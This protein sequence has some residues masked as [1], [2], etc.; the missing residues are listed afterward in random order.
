MGN[1]TLIMLTSFIICV[2]VIVIVLNLIQ[3]GRKN[4][5]RKALE[6]LEIEKNKIASS[7]IVPELAKV[8]SFLNNDKLKEMYNAWSLRLKE[9]KEEQIPKLTDMILE[10][11]YSLSKTDYK[12][13]MYK[14]A[15]LEIEVYKVR[16]NSNFLLGEI[17]EI[18]NS[19]EESRTIITKFRACYRELFQKFNDTRNAYGVFGDSIQNE[20]ENI[21]KRFEDFELIMDNNEFV[22]VA[23][24]ISIIDEMLKHM[25]IV[26][27]EVPSIVMML[28]SV[29]PKRMREVTD[30]YNQMLKS[31]YP[32]DY[33]N[34]EENLAA[35][36]QKMEDITAQVKELN[37]QDA[38]VELK[39]LLDF[40][41]SLFEDFEKEKI[42]R[43]AYEDK[44]M[45][46]RKK[47][48]KINRI[49]EELF[50]QISDIKITYDLIDEDIVS[51]K[52]VKDKLTELNDNYKLLLEHTSNNVFA[53]SK[54]VQDIEGFSIDLANIEDE[55]DHS[56]NT[57]G[58]MKDDEARARQQ[59]D[60]IKAILKDAKLKIREYNLPLIPNTYYTELNE[61][62][63]AIR[64]I[65]KELD[66]KPIT[67][68]VLNTRVDTARD[69]VL[70]LYTK[71][72]SMIKLAMLAEMTI[73][74]GNRYRSTYEGLHR[75]LQTAEQL[76]YRGEYQKSLDTSIDVLTKIDPNISTKISQFYMEK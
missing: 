53:F 23:K 34:V 48:G 20:F 54:L 36:K 49:V 6:E 16:T 22:E 70:K 46:F 33:L 8:E 62:S 28:F 19:E 17:K 18:T 56:L 65:V 52:N 69:L 39:V 24:I 2:V 35:A 74:Y 40:F 60:E 44:T 41:D 47:L 45:K 4:K 42:A 1:L 57:I 38:M 27:D 64:E 43:A 37:L 32:L 12:A 50:N 29:L 75:H 63:S 5:I 21:S 3:I 10:A 9:I 55:L 15:K 26:I 71:T 51:L 25:E 11:E 14:L 7:P 67:I 61:A 30:T 66:K 58:N 76:F 13:T 73:V 59:L 72:K 68:S 31:Q